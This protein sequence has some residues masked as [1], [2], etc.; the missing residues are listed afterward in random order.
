MGSIPGGIGGRG[1]CRVQRGRRFF[2]G[3]GRLVFGGRGIWSVH[4]D[5][6]LAHLLLEWNNIGKIEGGLAFEDWLEEFKANGKGGAGA[7]FFLAKRN[8]FVV[9]THPHP[10]SELWCEADEP[11]VRVI[12]SGARF[13]SRGAAERAGLNACTELNY[14][15]EHGSHGAGDVGRNHVVDFWMSFLEER[16]VVACYAADHVRIDAVTGCRGNGGGINVN[17]EGAAN[18]AECLGRTIK[19]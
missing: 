7:G 14:F 1:F 16:A 12:L 5:A 8:L 10:G 3:L 11:R 13:A 17:L 6:M 9:V 15:L 4:V 19:F 18:L 2:F